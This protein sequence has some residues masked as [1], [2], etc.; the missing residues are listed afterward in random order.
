MTTLIL[1]GSSG[2]PLD[3]VFDRLGE[4]GLA[5]PVVVGDGPL[6]D[7]QA[8]MQRL[9]QHA[10]HGSGALHP[11]RAWQVAASEIFLSNL[12]Q[13]CWGWASA[14]HLRLLDFWADFEPSIRFLLILLS[15]EE[16]IAR[17]QTAY[18]ADVDVATVLSV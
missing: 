8:W 18:G 4:A 5:P 11:G 17:A 13:P 12:D 16:A 2:C 9:T 6:R 15:P 7:P 1:G 14:Q 3:A 10:T